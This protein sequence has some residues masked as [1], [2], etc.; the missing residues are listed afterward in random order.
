M[1]NVRKNSFNVM[2]SEGFGKLSKGEHVDVAVWENFFCLLCPVIKAV[3]NDCHPK[4][5]VVSFSVYLRC[6]RDFLRTELG[7]DLGFVVLNPNVDKVA[8]RKV[9][10]LQ[11]TA[12]QRGMTLGA[13]LDLLLPGR[14]MHQK[15]QSQ[16][17]W[18]F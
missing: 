6:V 11:E 8:E 10:H 1:P 14:R 4:N 17:L 18:Q 2:M 7:P 5:L 15:C 12:S 9:A 13:F 3:K 16:K